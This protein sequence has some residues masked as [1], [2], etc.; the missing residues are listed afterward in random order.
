MVFALAKELSIETI[1]KAIHGGEMFVP[2]FM[3]KEFTWGEQEILNLLDNIF[4]YR[5]RVTF[6][7]ISP[8]FIS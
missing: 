7:V 5:Y 3:S 4:S 1:V 8:T 2:E 6:W